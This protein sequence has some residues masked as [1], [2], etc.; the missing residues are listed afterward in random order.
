DLLGRPP[1]PSTASALADLNA[2]RTTRAQLAALVVGSA[3]YRGRFVNQA[4]LTTLK[5]AATPADVDFWAR[6]VADN[7]T[8][9]LRVVLMSCDEAAIVCSGGSV[10]GWVDNAYRLVLGRAADPTERAFYVNS[11]LDAFAADRQSLAGSMI[12]SADARSKQVSDLYRT[13]LGRS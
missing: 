2:G 9:A 7:G 1:D 6:Y 12:A 3:E 10:A 5:R 8:L 4:Y 13:L 11:L